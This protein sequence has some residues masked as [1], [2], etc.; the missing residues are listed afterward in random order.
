MAD[1]STDP[2]EQSSDCCTWQ[3]PGVVSDHDPAWVYQSRVSD[4]RISVRA[5]D[6]QPYGRATDQKANPTGGQQTRRPDLYRPDNRQ[7]PSLPANQRPPAP[8]TANSTEVSDEQAQINQPDEPADYSNY[9]SQSFQEPTSRMIEIGSFD[10]GLEQGLVPGFSQLTVGEGDEPV[11][12]TGA[13]HHLTGNRGWGPMFSDP[14]WANR[15]S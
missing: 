1:G 3:L 15:N 6:G 11:V 2:Y 14:Q 5:A 12:D 9:S 4:A 10:E 7:R 8:S 13:T